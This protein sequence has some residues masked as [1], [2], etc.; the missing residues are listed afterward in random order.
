MP[1]SRATFEVVPGSRRRLSHGETTYDDALRRRR[2]RAR[3]CMTLGTTPVVRD[4]ARV[5]STGCQNGRRGTWSWLCD[6]ERGAR[7]PRSRGARGTRGGGRLRLRSRRRI[8]SI[9][10]STGRGTARSCGASSAGS[11]PAPSESASERA[12]RA[13]PCASIRRSS[14]RQPRPRRR[15]CPAGSFSESA[16]A[17]TSTSTFSATG[18]PRPTC[19]G[20]CSRR[21]SRSCASSGEGSSR[22]TADATT[23]SRTR[24]STRF[25]TSRST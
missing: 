23:P 1:R 2:R 15:C 22:P 13:R 5:R 14:P 24:A 8:T 17:R 18:G 7:A 4:H 25:P 20:R 3:P 19:A 11:P 21:P 10:G 12:S 16:R 6:L 9:P